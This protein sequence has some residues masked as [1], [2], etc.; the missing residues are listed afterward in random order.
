MEVYTDV[1]KEEIQNIFS[2]AGCAIQ[3]QFTTP[4]AQDYC[5]FLNQYLLQK[6]DVVIRFYS[7]DG[8]FRDLSFLEKLSNIKNLKVHDESVTN[9]ESVSLVK[10]L[11]S[12]SIAKTRNAKLSLKPLSRLSNLCSVE[13]NGQNSILD[14]IESSNSLNELYLENINIG[15]LVKLSH[16]QKMENIDLFKCKCSN[17]QALIK[18][19][20]LKYLSLQKQA[21][22]DFAFIESLVQI[23][24]LRLESLA[25]IE[26]P[27]F[28]NCQKLK[29]IFLSSL[30]NLKDY[31]MLATA[32]SLTEIALGN[33]K[34]L[35]VSDFYFLEDRKAIK[36]V[37]ADIKN[38]R[39]SF[40]FYAFLTSIGL[41]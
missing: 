20:K 35:E 5:S 19:P 40:D 34:Q 18:M 28:S 33:V 13:V 1:L 3:L 26:L 39:N 21:V 37:V 14:V 36:R 4:P 15:D 11:K 25:I 23:E 17:Y 10:E 22:D 16:L 7:Y 12:F 30:P 27:D 9:I 31:K 29:R 8:Y 38:K 6:D 41:N 2:N 32:G 24:Q